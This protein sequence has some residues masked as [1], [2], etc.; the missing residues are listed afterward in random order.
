VASSKDNGAR[1][2]HITA[3]IIIAI[4]A[5]V[6]IAYKVR[7]AVTVGP[8]WDT[9]AFLANAAD[10]AGK[11]FGYT[12]AHRAPMLSVITSLVFRFGSLNQAAIQWIDGALSFT[13]IVGFYLLARRRFDILPS[14]ACAL[15]LLTAQP[16]WEYLGVGYTDFAAIAVSIWL[17]LS[18][19][20]ATE[21][22][23]SWYLASGV[24]YVVAVM[25]RYTAILFLFPTIVYLLLRWRP[26]RQARWVFGGAGAAIL[27]Y[28]PAALY[29]GQRFGDVLF[30]FV[31]A[32][33]FSE[34]VAAPTGEVQASASGGWYLAQL[35]Q[36]LAP[37]GFEILALFALA[38]G[39]LG[40]LR[41]AGDYVAAL[42]FSPR[43]ILL[44]LAGLG[45][46]VLGQ[47]AGG[48]FARQLSI[49]IAVLLIWTALAPMQDDGSGRPPRVEAHAALD[50]A[51]FAWVLIYLDF[52]GHQTIQ[53]PRYFI[54]MAPSVLYFTILGWS[55]WANALSDLQQTIGARKEPSV[56]L[57]RVVMLTLS[58][59]LV[60]LLSAT[61]LTTDQTPDPFVEAAAESSAEMA[62]RDPLI[63]HRTIYS[64]LWPVVAWYLQTNVRA[65]P[66]YEDIRG[67]GHEL[68][69]SAAD[70]FF[71]I[72]G[73]RFE[74]YDE[75]L[76]HGA[77]TVLKRRLPPAT[78]AL[79]SVQYLGKAW[80]NYLEPTTD[81]HF[82]LQ[83]TAGRYGWEGSAFL[84]GQTAAELAQ[85]D[86]VAA[87]GWRWRN[88]AEAEAILL[89]Y[90]ENGGV[91]VLDASQNLD[92]LAYS[93][94]GTIMF[95]TFIRST[96]LPPKAQIVPNSSFARAHPEVGD[97]I[98]SPFVDETGGSWSGATYEARPGTP[99]LNTLATVGGRPAIQ[100]RTIGEGTVY[101]I[102]YNLVWHAFSTENAQEQ[103]L[104][105]AVFDE[106]ISGGSR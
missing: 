102:S 20:K 44:A 62:Q 39:A 2:L 41:L 83:S 22:H 90:V 85:Y 24:L 65:M 9:Y 47:L 40:L 100:S 23:P 96:P 46:G 71:T 59:L 81:Y 1:L 37:T 3:L 49:P 88:R 55:G 15:G 63:T 17:L 28:L 84:D 33:G 78:D 29:Y 75:V 53:V 79:P 104:I 30:P 36:F 16:L 76:R 103:A 6:L 8:G 32:L 31:V 43:R 25:T 19:V 5:A 18:I 58:A 92:G 11:G 77:L 10:F 106:A 80:D 82:Y 74:P 21:E 26:F 69:K 57:R 86:A 98:A 95:D 73:R 93:V 27:A 66:A 12:E 35:P 61:A 70:Y 54:T 72:R 7:I 14:V 68:E 89:E 51:M 48:L 99:P 101:F 105:T 91:I 13:G 87:Y 67:Y 42:G 50:A 45:V 38:A 64:D 97:V 52:H 56:G 4:T 34:T 60:G 94:A